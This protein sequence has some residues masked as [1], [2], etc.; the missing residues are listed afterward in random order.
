MFGVGALAITGAFYRP[1]AQALLPS[2]ATPERIGQANSALRLATSLAAIAGPAV[3]AFLV[4][5]GGLSLV[6]AVDAVSFVVSALLVMTLRRLPPQAV[7][8][9]KGALRE[10]W[11][12]FH[13]SVEHRPILTVTVA[14]GVVMLVG[15]LVNAGTLPLVRGPLDLEA[16]RYGVL[17]AIE[18]GGA[19][20]LAS[21]CSCLA[22][23]HGSWSPGR[24][25]SSV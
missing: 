21:R 13:Y 16:S 25:R 23:V 14:I 17:L 15:T 7:S 22:Q 1:A 19:M 11:A 9:G 18:G 20:A 2:L 5:H 12:G 24:S 6:L 8:A 4:T 10:A 3:G